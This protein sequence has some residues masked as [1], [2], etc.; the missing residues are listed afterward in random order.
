MKAAYRDAFHIAGGFLVVSQKLHDVLVKFDL[1]DTRLHRVPIFRDEERTPSQIEPHYVLHV[2]EQKLDTFVPSASKNV[3]EMRHRGFPDGKPLRVWQSFGAPDELAVN[4]RS[5]LG[6]ILWA[7]PNLISR[8]F[9]TDRLK[10]AIEEAGVKSR[11]L[12]F[13]K[14][15]L[16]D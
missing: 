13:Q 2:S 11:A 8:F 1:G 6:L 7:D 10:S 9:L 4:A 16:V 3:R 15:I 14:A 12:D 5:A